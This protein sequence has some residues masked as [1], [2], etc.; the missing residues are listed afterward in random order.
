MSDIWF[1]QNN[2]KKDEKMEKIIKLQIVRAMLLL[3]DVQDAFMEPVL[4][5]VQVVK[6][7][8]VLAQAAGI[9]SLP[10]VVTEQYP[11]GLGHTVAELACKCQGHVVLEKVSFSC[12]GQPEVTATIESYSRKQVIIAGVE[13]HVCIQQTVIDLLRNGYEVFVAA[14][15]VSSR[16]ETDLQFALGRMGQAGAVITTVE[17]IVLELLGSSRHEHFKAVQGLIK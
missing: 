6:K 2:W 16:N 10:T 8:G 14:D 11:R 1:W 17:A 5:M 4:N 9:L 7:C 12:L 13:A 3:V 15:A